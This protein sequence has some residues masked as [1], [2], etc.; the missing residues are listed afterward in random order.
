MKKKS[1]VLIIWS[2]LGAVFRTQTSS[3]LDKH[4]RHMLLYQKKSRD[5]QVISERLAD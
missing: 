2:D 5:W 4:G 3:A 1:P